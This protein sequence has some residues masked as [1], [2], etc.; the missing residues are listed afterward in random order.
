MHQSSGTSRS[1]IPIDVTERSKLFT[2]DPEESLVHRRRPIIEPRALVEVGGPSDWRPMHP[3]AALCTKR[4]PPNW[5]GCGS[6]EV[7]V[8]R[9]EI[10]EL[11]DGG[12]LRH[13]VG[14]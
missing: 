4:R 7:V 13:D 6:V 8:T 3:R 11:E 5:G 10:E 14:A 12:E 1:P 2:G 9:I